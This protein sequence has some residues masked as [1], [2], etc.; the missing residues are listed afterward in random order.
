MTQATRKELSVVRIFQGNP[1]LVVGEALLDEQY[2]ERMLDEEYSRRSAYLAATIMQPR[3][4]ILSL[5][6]ATWKE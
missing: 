2:I 6:L 1:E 4:G 3:R 5:W